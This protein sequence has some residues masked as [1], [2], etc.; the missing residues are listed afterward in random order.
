MSECKA[1]VRRCSFEPTGL[2]RA[3]VPSRHPW[4]WVEETRSS[5]LGWIN[6]NQCTCRRQ[7]KRTS[8]TMVNIPLGW[9]WWQILQAQECYSCYSC[10]R[11]QSRNTAPSLYQRKP[12]GSGTVSGCQSFQKWAVREGTGEILIPDKVRI[13]CNMLRNILHILY[14]FPSHI[15]PDRRLSRGLRSLY[16][17]IAASA[18]MF[19]A[20]NK[21]TSSSGLGL[22]L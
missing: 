21:A 1:M 19:A 13:A 16:V 9:R 18:M 7:K 3:R 15:H 5:H 8:K 6:A 10:Y 17:Q 12:V 4:K 2:P 20:A 22:L 14:H 11:V